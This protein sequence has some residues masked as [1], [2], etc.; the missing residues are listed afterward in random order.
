MGL[1]NAG[2]TTYSEQFKNVCHTDK[3]NPHKW[4]G[5]TKLAKEEMVLDGLFT[6]RKSRIKLLSLFD[7]KKKT[8]IWID[9]PYEVC[10]E[11]SSVGRHIEAVINNYNRFE[12]PTYEEGWDEIIRICPKSM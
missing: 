6:T 11:R 5:I 4:E 8:L 10:L 2:K 7:W 1:P 3:L 12:P 9:T